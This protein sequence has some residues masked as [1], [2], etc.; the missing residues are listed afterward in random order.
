M[1]ENKVSY[2]VSGRKTAA[3]YLISVFFF[4]V[5]AAAQGP[6][7]S[8]SPGGT[9]HTIAGTGQA[10]FNQ[11]NGAAVSAAL[12]SP[13]AM[14]ADAAGNLYIADR[15]NHRIRKVDTNGNITT[16]AGNGTQGFFGDGGLATSAGL[17]TP[18][19][20]AVDASGNL[21]IADSNS[22]RIRVVSNGNIATFAGNGTAGFSGDNGAATSAALNR[23]KGVAV[24]ASGA[25]YIA[26]TGNHVV[27]K[28]SGG[29]ITTIA[30]NGTQGFFGDQGA[31]ASASL[32]TPLAVIVDASNRLF[33]ADNGNRRVRMV[34]GTTISTFAGNGNPGFAGDGGQAAAAALDHPT[35]LAVDS[36]GNLYIAD[37]NNNVVR[38][39][40]TAGVITSVAANGTEGYFGDNGSPAFASLD[41]PTGVLV[42]NGN[43]LIADKNNQRVR[44]AD[45][46]LL[47]FGSH[48]L[49]SSSAAKSVTVTNAGAA[50]LTL[51]SVTSSLGDY[52]LLASG[53][54]GTSFPKTLSSGASCTLNVAFSPAAAGSRTAT[55]AL[56]D[57]AEGSPQL[58]YLSGAGTETPSTI[59]LTAPASTL[60]FGAP[61]TFTAT[62]TGTGATGWVVFTDGGA[63]VST[64][65]LN[66]SGVAAFTDSALSAG[67]H[68]I[69]ANYQGDQNFA[70][71]S[72]TPLLINV[73]AQPV[74]NSLTPD[75][76]TS[77]SGDYTL[78]VNGQ[79]FVA[80][81]TVNWNGSARTTT[82]VSSSQ[83]TA[84]IQASDVASVG[85]A[86]VTVVNPGLSGT[87][88]IFTIPIDNPSG[89]SGLISVSTQTLNVTV[90]KGQSVA[91]PFSTAGGSNNSVVSGT[92]ANLPAGVT[93]NVDSIAKVITLTASSSATGGTYSIS[94]IFTS[95][96]PGA[97]LAHSRPL[98]ALWSGLMGL[99]LGLFWIGGSRRK[100]LRYRLGLLIGVML[101]M[102]MAGCGGKIQSSSAAS[103]QTSMTLT[104]T[105]H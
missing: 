67:T 98:L 90:S 36:L 35:G 25:V 46:T 76:A 93:C 28:V 62:V 22:N 81:A 41:T 20:V 2:R 8:L 32:N 4:L 40:D 102:T 5:Q 72:A 12:A 91:V 21:Y 69:G 88:A 100:P 75:S 38:R 31:A 80:G 43:L 48:A 63:V 99:P 68:S 33:I 7:I 77:G 39:V 44:Q 42:V 101:L 11:D 49:N 10:T 18:T 83:V 15:N 54:C 96:S 37:A 74:I 17:D 97:S 70:A 92:C 64:V 94:V 6:V 65:Q 78:T 85:T 1:R 13:F 24:D 84:A 50:T 66:G 3:L 103:A 55:L 104:L 51:T 86:E 52:T 16:I 23:P 9:L 79:Y 19:S 45:A 58:V 105:V 71:S 57:N 95:T 30:G 59:A 82:W 87:S 60:L 47:A 34:S 73:V 53:T 14:A 26:D 89:T 27:R 61:L 56:A 29:T